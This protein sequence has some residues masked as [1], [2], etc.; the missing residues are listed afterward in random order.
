LEETILVKFR[1]EKPSFGCPGGDCAREVND[2]RLQAACAERRGQAI[3][4]GGSTSTTVRRCSRPTHHKRTR[5]GITPLPVGFIKGGLR[6]LKT[7]GHKR[8]RI[9]VSARC[10]ARRPAWPQ[11]AQ[12]KKIRRPLHGL[13]LPLLRALCHNRCL[14]CLAMLLPGSA[15]QEQY[16]GSL[17]C[18]TGRAR[19]RHTRCGHRCCRSGRSPGRLRRRG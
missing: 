7:P 3:T 5:G 13:L 10:L 16:A 18:V 17:T 15:R 8:G 11:P 4:A 14:S 2:I 1:H 6:T 9:G 19:S 12:P